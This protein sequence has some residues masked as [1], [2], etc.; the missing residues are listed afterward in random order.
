MGLPAHIVAFRV[1]V[2]V[3]VRARQRWVPVWGGVEGGYCSCYDRGR[4]SWDHR[5]KKENQEQ[6]NGQQSLRI[7]PSDSAREDIGRRL[8]GCSAPVGADGL[9][10][11]SW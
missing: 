9:P 1:G 10:R 7:A 4:L 2:L 8:L 5:E 11:C 3:A 6:K